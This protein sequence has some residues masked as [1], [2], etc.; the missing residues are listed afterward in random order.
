MSKQLLKQLIIVLFAI[1]ILCVL[2]GFM[3]FAKPY[4]LH[5][6]V[7]NFTISA[8]AVILAVLSKIE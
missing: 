4:G 8:V 7:F 2:I 3:D 6:S 5:L 1:V